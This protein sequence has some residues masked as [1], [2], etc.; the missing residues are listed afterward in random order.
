M[1][2]ELL[3]G[4][5]HRK[6]P[7]EKHHRSF[8]QLCSVADC[9]F[10]FHSLPQDVIPHELLDLY[11]SMTDPSRAQTVDSEI[12][13]HCA[14]SL[15]GVALTLGRHNWQCLKLVYDTLASDM[16]VRRRN[17]AISLLL[18]SIHQ[19]QFTRKVIAFNCISYPS[20]WFKQ[21][22]ETHTAYSTGTQYRP[23]RQ[24]LNE[25][26]LTWLDRQ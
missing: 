25:K 24:S 7:A 22:L 11:L 18:K 9:I 5:S 15:P 21:I 20:N 17:R 3:W 6:C 19:D 12:A 10:H 26:Q 2:P 14:F 23:T 13:R 8:F 4:I 16:Q 1:L